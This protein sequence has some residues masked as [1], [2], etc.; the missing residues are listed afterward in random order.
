MSTL[1]QDRSFPAVSTAARTSLCVAY[2]MAILFKMP[3]W[4][5]SNL[6]EMPGPVA[7]A[8]HRFD[9]PDI[10]SSSANDATAERLSR[11]S[12]WMMG[13]LSRGESSHKVP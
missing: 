7:C 9:R 4:A 2:G 10:Q 11:T 8:R 6:D 13:I 3:P 5:R 1:P 12:L